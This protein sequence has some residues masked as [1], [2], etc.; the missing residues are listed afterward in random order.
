MKTHVYDN[1]NKMHIDTPLKVFNRQTNII[2][3]GNVIANT[4]YSSHIRA[5]NTAKNPVGRDVKPGEMQTFDLQHFP[6]ANRS[7]FD[8]VKKHAVD[9]NVILYCFFHHGR[10]GRIMHGYVC[11]TTDHD[12][13]FTYQTRNDYRS[14]MVLDCCAEY[15]C[16]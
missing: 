15:I 4:Q 3:D 9:K 13:I 10:N 11:T 12:R 2:T 1:P 8:L 14:G 7:V 6:I 16:N 5:F